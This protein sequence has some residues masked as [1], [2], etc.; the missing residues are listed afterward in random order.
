MPHRVKHSR[1]LNLLAAICMVSANARALDDVGS[2]VPIEQ[3]K[4]K[5][6]AFAVNLTQR[7]S[8]SG[9]KDI[10]KRASIKPADLGDDYNL[11]SEKFYMYVPKEPADDGKF[12]LMVGLC[13]KEYGHPA[14]AWTDVLEKKHLIWIGAT[15]N[16][17][18]REP[19]QRIGLLLDAVNGVEKNWTIDT[20]RVYLSMNAGKGPALGTAFYYS[21]V[22]TGMLGSFYGH[23]FVKLKGH[24]NPP[25]TWD[26]DNFPRPAS[27]NLDLAK[28]QTRVFQASRDSPGNINTIDDLVKRAFTT[29]GFKYVKFVRV[30]ES[31]MGHYIDYAADWFEQGIDFMDEPLPKIRAARQPRPK[32]KLPPAK[33]P[34]E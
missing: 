21:D 6:G 5:T 7:S 9:L 8:L 19:A 33:A 34:G 13:F 28:S 27:K 16:G 24:E 10:G 32:A 22:F 23:W 4:T 2:A 12:G 26:S 1:L 29:A 15:S 20:D 31:N 14:T 3:A 18:D 17:D 25:M 30:P 11:A